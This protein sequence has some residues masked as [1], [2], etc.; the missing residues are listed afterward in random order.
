[1]IWVVVSG[2]AATF[3][4]AFRAIVSFGIEAAGFGVGASVL[5]FFGGATIGSSFGFEAAVIF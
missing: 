3:L 4:L 1:M 2:A 5:T